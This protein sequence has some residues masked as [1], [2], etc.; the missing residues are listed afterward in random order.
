MTWLIRI[1]PIDMRI[2]GCAENK[3]RKSG[4]RAGKDQSRS[5]AVSCI[6]H[7]SRG[8]LHSTGIIA[9]FKASK[10]RAPPKGG[11]SLFSPPSPFR[12]QSA[13]SPRAVQKEAAESD[14]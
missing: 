2:S 14:I 11:S 5:G 4:G 7:V 8:E 10:K 13:K 6:G 3:A 12:L 1:F 9:Q